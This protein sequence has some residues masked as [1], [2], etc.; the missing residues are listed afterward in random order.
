[1]LLLFGDRFR[2][3]VLLQFFWGQNTI[4]IHVQL[5]EIRKDQVA[6]I[7]IHFP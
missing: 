5:V 1:M 4:T 2:I 7:I 3:D 6:E